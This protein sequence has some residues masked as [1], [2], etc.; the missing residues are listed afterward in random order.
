MDVYVLNTW[1]KDS[2]CFPTCTLW[3]YKYDLSCRFGKCEPKLLRVPWTARFVWA[4]EVLCLSINILDNAI[5][6]LPSVLPARLFWCPI[7]NIGCTWLRANK[8]VPLKSNPQRK[9]SSLKERKNGF[10]S[11]CSQISPF[12][13]RSAR[14]FIKE[15]TFSKQP[16][17][18]FC[19]TTF[20]DNMTL[21]NTNKQNSSWH[22]TLQLQLKAD[23]KMNYMSWNT[24]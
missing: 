12:I 20:L 1:N 16:Q 24:E 2:H 15:Y 21:H 10:I 17:C 4:L 6:I 23:L 9:V 18:Y 8:S 7:M 13:S 22:F 14:S 19:T 3:K 11:V 5:Y